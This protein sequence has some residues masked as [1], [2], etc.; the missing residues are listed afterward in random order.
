MVV[1]GSD[2]IRDRDRQR[3]RALIQ[4]HGFPSS[5]SSLSLPSSAAPTLPVVVDT[6]EPVHSLILFDENEISRRRYPLHGS[7]LCPDGTGQV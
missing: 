4:C 6:K 2:V 7:C 5:L 1:I 3:D